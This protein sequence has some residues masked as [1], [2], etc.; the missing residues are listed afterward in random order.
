M[1][2]EVGMADGASPEGL[3]R[4]SGQL[5]IGG[6]QHQTVQFGLGS[7]QAIK[8]IAIGL[9]VRPRP[10]PMGMATCSSSR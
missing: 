5:A 1:Q 8:G 2:S 7:Q 3:A 6:E 9:A 10:Q 4:K